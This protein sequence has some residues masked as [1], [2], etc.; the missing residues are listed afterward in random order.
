MDFEINDRTYTIVA[1]TC[2]W[3]DDGHVLHWYLAS[4]IEQ[5]DVD[6]RVQA[7]H[8]GECERGNLPLNNVIDMW[9]AYHV[10]DVHTVRTI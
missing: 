9:R 2:E 10:I 4:D 5:T 7:E 1:T 8:D 3:F 6:K